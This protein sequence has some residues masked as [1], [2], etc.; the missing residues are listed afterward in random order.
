MTIHQL[1]LIKKSY[2]E[3]EVSE[4]YTRDPSMEIQ[5]QLRKY[6]SI[7]LAVKW[8]CTKNSTMKMC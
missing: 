5:S 8:T 1:R 3:M 6:F 7:K 4:S 2:W